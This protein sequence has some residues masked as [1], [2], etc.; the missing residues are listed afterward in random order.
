MHWCRTLVTSNLPSRSLSDDVDR[1][2]QIATNLEPPPTLVR[3]VATS[4][5]GQRKGRRPRATGIRRLAQPRLLVALSY[6]PFR[7]PPCAPKH[8]RSAEPTRT[9]HLV[10]HSSIVLLRRVHSRPLLSPLDLLDSRPLRPLLR[11]TSMG[12]LFPRSNY[13]RSFPTRIVRLPSCYHANNLDRSFNRPERYQH[14]VQL[15]DSTARDPLSPIGMASF[16]S[17]ACTAV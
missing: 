3:T 15:P 17:L 6:L 1:I 10:P 2:L 7:M 9:S 11:Q 5:A 16:V 8:T 4:P 14:Y 12:P 13:P